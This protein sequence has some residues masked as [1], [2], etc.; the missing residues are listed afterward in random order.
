MTIAK[1]IADAARPIVITSGE[2]E[3]GS[4]D[5]YTGKRTI[6]AVKL[7][8]ARERCGGDRWA[9]AI[10]Y[11]HRSEWGDVWLDVETGD[12]APAP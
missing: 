10:V 1:M 9:R 12:Y 7:R 8:L 11:S 3:I 5:I 6:R 4:D 2:G